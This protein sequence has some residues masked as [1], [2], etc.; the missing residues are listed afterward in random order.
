MELMFTEQLSSQLTERPLMSQRKRTEQLHR[1]T[2]AL[3][4]HQR[5]AS[6]RAKG[7]TRTQALQINQTIRKRKNPKKSKRKSKIPHQQQLIASTLIRPLSRRSNRSFT[8][9]Q[10][11]QKILQK[12]DLLSQWMT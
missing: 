11:E 3:L 12:L 7:K 10:L 6:L 5:K 4:I 2:L 1:R 8:S 9:D